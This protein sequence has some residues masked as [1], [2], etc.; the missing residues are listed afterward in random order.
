MHYIVVHLLTVTLSLL[1]NTVGMSLAPVLRLS[2]TC[3]SSHYFTEIALLNNGNFE[4]CS[5]T[6]E[7]GGEKKERF[8]LDIYNVEKIQH[9]P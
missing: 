4:L 8:E 5:Y 7:R 6:A 1:V 2:D 3:L 9:L